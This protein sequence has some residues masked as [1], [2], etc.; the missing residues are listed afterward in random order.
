VTDDPRAAGA[1]AVV[2]GLHARATASYAR[3]MD[4]EPY[5]HVLRARG[6]ALHAA[7]VQRAR[8][9]RERLAEVVRVLVEDFQVH[10]VTLF[11]SLR[12][13]ELYGDSDLD[14]AVEGLDPYDY[15]RALD[16]VTVAAGIPVDLVRVEEASAPVVARIE[17]DGEVLH[18]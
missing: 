18:G 11:G 1:A 16:R 6:R 7:R 2:D 3:R 4:L 12:R 8:A 9:V 5:L 10:R 15:W 14:L 13:G 17:D